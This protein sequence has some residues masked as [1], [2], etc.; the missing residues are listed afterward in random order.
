MLNEINQSQKDKCFK[1]PLYEVH[2]IVK[3]KELEW[4]GGCQWLGGVAGES[5]I[6]GHKVSVKE[7]E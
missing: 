1:I 3:F 7:N 6:R 4:N 2:K 5:L